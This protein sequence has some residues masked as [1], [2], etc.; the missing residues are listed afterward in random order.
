MDWMPTAVL[1][2]IF[3]LGIPITLAVW[4][5]VRAVSAKNRIEELSRRLGGLE[6]EIFRLKRERESAKPVEPAPKPVPVSQVKAAAP[7]P[8]PPFQ[9]A[10]EPKPAFTLPTR[11]QILQSQREGL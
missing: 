5:I 9:P 11:E 10:P 6:S 4:L 2:F 1:V 3:V 8:I 7:S